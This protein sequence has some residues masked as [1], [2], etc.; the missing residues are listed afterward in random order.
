MVPPGAFPLVRK[1]FVWSSRLALA[2]ANRVKF[3]VR[4]RVKRGQPAPGRARK[5]WRGTL[6]KRRARQSWSWQDAGPGSTNPRS[7]TVVTGTT[8]AAETEGSAPVIAVD[9]GSA[10]DPVHP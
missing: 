7:I 3:W 2:C 8:P 5:Q 1:L 9:P 10:V 4:P 6:R